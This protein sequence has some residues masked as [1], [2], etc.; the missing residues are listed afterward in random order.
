MDRSGIMLRQLPRFL[1]PLSF[2]FFLSLSAAFGVLMA[3]PLYAATTVLDEKDEKVWPQPPDAPK[4]KYLDAFRSARDLGGSKDAVKAIEAPYGVAAGSDGRVYVTSRGSVAIFDRE[5]RSV[6]FIGKSEGPGKLTGAV[7]VAVTRE[8]RI[9]VADAAARAVFSYSREGKYTATLGSP[10]ELESPSGIAVDEGTKRIYVADM[11]KHRIAAYSLTDNRL[12]R[13]IG[14]RGTSGE[15]KFNFP[16]NL[17]VDSKGSLY[18]AD[19]GN[20]RVQVFD[21]DGRFVRSIGKLGSLPGFFA[22]PK[23]V[24]VDSDNHL[25]VVDAAFQNVQVFDVDGR[26]LLFFGAG[27]WG[28]GLFTLPAGIAIDGRDRIYVV[29]QWPGNVQLFQYVGERAGQDTVTR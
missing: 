18:V 23:G 16:T 14:G 1:T 25:Y 17:A 9:F 5:R 20:F 29:D 6:G 28:P 8:G 4:I 11:K 2:L 13:T 19:T 15:G 27:G 3:A 7:G 12:I 22:R 10:G 24:A 26:L 21:R